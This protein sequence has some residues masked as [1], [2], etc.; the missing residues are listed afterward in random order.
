MAGCEKQRW[1]K[2]RLLIGK[3]FLV[4]LGN[5]LLRQLN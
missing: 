5:E 2:G 3:P 1:Q 4:E